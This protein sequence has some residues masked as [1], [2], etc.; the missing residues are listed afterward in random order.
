MKSQQSLKTT[1]EIE[2]AKWN[3]LAKD[4]KLGGMLLRDGD[5]FS[6]YA[7]RTSTMVGVDEF[8]G[9]LRGKRV[10]EYGCGLGEITLLLAKSGAKVNA[11]DL[12]EKS[13]S[14]TRERVEINDA[15]KQTQL[16]VAAGEHLPYAS[17][18]FDV[19]FGKA[20]LH[21]L[22]VHVGWHDLHRIIKKGGKAVFVEPMGMNPLI[23]FARNHLPYPHKNPR[24]ADRPLVYWE[25]MK[26]GQRFS[27]FHFKEIQLT[28]MLERA[29]GFG[30]R[31]HALRRLDG[32]LL[33]H[34]PFLRRYCRY[35]VMYMV[36]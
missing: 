18:S 25:I 12:S 17:A 5:N 24:G 27:K 23:N 11:F 22:D 15:G 1:Y 35:V 31:I 19:V 4:E 2:R 20:I 26:W 16:T 21:H 9:D 32:Y 34:F 3:E 10:L 14:I 29:L 7:H 33:K 30:V 36:K 8:L 6:K 28:S 13:V